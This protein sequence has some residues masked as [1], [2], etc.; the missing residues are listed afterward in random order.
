MERLS[1]PQQVEG[2]ARGASVIQRAME[3]VTTWL[4]NMGTILIGARTA[5]KAGDGGFTAVHFHGPNQ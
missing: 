2:N 3:D 5:A 1:S 4:A